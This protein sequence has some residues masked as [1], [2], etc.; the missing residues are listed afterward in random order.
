MRRRPRLSA[1]RGAIKK[2]T[3]EINQTMAHIPGWE[4]EDSRQEAVLAFCEAREDFNA[5]RGAKF[6][7]WLFN[8]TRWLM[9]N[10]RRS[11]MKYYGRKSAGMK[12]T[13]PVHDESARLVELHVM[14]R[15]APE[16]V[17]RLIDILF[18]APEDFLLF[19]KEQGRKRPTKGLLAEYMG[20]NS[21]RLTSAIK[22]IKEEVIAR[23]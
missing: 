5:E 1:Y 19:V 3:G 16:D 2:L 22:W 23:L 8:R 18:G 6:S 12:R 15:S 13:P 17:R 21:R 4:E 9:H 20:V 14:I 11:E 10:R 7:T